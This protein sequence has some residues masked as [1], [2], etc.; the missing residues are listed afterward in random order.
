MADAE[1]KAE[2]GLVKG[3]GSLKVRNR[4]VHRVSLVAECLVEGACHWCGSLLEGLPHCA[5]LQPTAGA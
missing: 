1:P 3:K 4:E 2:D 5:W